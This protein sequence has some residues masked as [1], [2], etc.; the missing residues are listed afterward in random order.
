M[1]DG[2]V[3][4]TQMCMPKI[5]AGGEGD[6]RGGGGGGDGGGVHRVEVIGAITSVQ[7]HPCTEVLHKETKTIKFNSERIIMS[8][9]MNGDTIFN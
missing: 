9:T 4:M 2:G 7:N 1:K 3:G 8:K 6:W 5:Y